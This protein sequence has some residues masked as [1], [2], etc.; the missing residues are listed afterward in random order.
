MG[1]NRWMKA[2]KKEVELRTKNRKEE[3]GDE[4]GD[5]DKT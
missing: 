2:R 5:E 3:E 1:K 4:E